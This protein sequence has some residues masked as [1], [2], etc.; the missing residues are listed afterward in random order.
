MLFDGPRAP[1]GPFPSVRLQFT[2]AIVITVLSL[3]AFCAGAQSPNGRSAQQLPPITVNPPAPVAPEAGEPTQRAVSTSNKSGSRKVARKAKSTPQSQQDQIEADTVSRDPATALGTY[4]PALD[5]PQAA[6]PEGSTMTTAGPVRGYRALTSYSSTKTATPIEE[7]PQ[8]IQIVPRKVIEDQKPLTVTEAVQNVSNVQGPNA[9]SLGDTQL[10]PYTIRGFGAQA[11]LDGMV[12]PFSLGDRDA[13][14]NVERIEVLKGPNAILYG[15]GAGAPIG[16]AVNIISKLPTDRAFGELGFT[17]GSH[18]FLQ[19]YFDVNQPLSANGTV[20]FR[21]TGEYTASDSFIDVLEQDRYSLNP[22]LTLTNKTDTTLTVQG[23][24]SKSKQQTYQGLPVTGTLFGGFQLDRDLFIGPRGIP[25]G[26]S[27]VQG[28][29][30]TLDHKF[31]DF[32]SGSIKAR[33]SKGGFEQNTQLAAS[34]DISGAT[35]AMPPST[36]L[37]ANTVLH[38]NIEEVS[39]NPTA[40]AQFSWGES[41]NTLLIGADYSRVRDTGLLMTDYLGNGCA[42]FFG[43]AP[44]FGLVGPTADLTNPSFGTPYRD[45]RTVTQYQ[46]FFGFDQIVTWGDATNTYTTMGAYAQLQTTLYER[47]HLLAGLRGTSIK[48]EQ[49]EMAL[50][51]PQETVTDADKI[52]PRAG[53][54]IDLLPGLSAYASYSEG[55]RALPRQMPTGMS[56]PEESEQREVGLKFALAQQLTGTVSYFEIDRDNVVVNL[57]LGATARAKQRATGFEA[58]LLWQPSSNWQVLASYGNTNAEFGDGL[59]GA[60]A[61]NKF[62]IVPE[63]SGRLWLNY[64]FDEA[65]LKGW[66]VGA[67]LYAA[68]SQ[69]VDVANLYKVDSY[70]TV[71]AKV[72]YEQ[73]NFKAALYI[74][75]L[76]GEEYL[77]PYAFLGGQ[78]APSEARAVY[79]TIAYKY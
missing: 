22:T 34:S 30:A 74:K 26:Y 40:K 11:W 56:V 28:I 61:G 7:I 67:G 78:V 76:T 16:G 71:D 55:I 42:A 24:L 43:V 27:E 2:V 36:W 65:V 70:F 62:P 19:P 64:R 48:V 10:Y 23:R 37:L 57:G 14:A 5:T 29:T 77:I 6:L 44:C 46:D 58:D 53:L 21:I 63:H 73:E 25:R 35:P 15:G 17:F 41:R 60:P 49:T 31:N 12:M 72:A 38:Q 9:R 20:L 8:S 79:G 59:L 39:I 32:W 1:Q 52:L 66:S 75:N 54:L 13:F 69:F 3:T 4:N 33:W 18:G 51:F 47:I 45:P 50:G 68:S